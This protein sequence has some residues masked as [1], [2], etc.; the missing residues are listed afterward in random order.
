MQ[1]ISAGDVYFL[2]SPF[3][4]TVSPQHEKKLAYLLGTV[5]A[6]PA[7]VVRPPA[8]WDEYS[9]VDVIPSLTNG[10]PSITLSLND[11]FGYKTA[12]DYNFMPHTTHTVP[13]G[14]LGRYI[15][16]LTDAEYAEIMYAFHW[17][18]DRRM[19]ANPDMYAVPECYREVM[20]RE[21]PPVSAFHAKDCRFNID[22]NMV[23]HA[24]GSNTKDLDG[25]ALSV[26]FARSITPTVAAK[27]ERDP[28]YH[29]S[30]PVITQKSVQE[31]VAI[32]DAAPA[33]VTK[34]NGTGTTKPAEIN[35]PPSTFDQV[36]LSRVAK[37]YTLFEKYYP[38]P[39]QLEVRNPAVLTP[40]E[41]KEIRGDVG[42][43]RMKDLIAYYETFT[44]FDAW[45]L[46]PYLPTSTLSKMIGFTI[47]ETAALKRLCT[48]FKGM[49]ENAYRDRLDEM[50]KPDTSAPTQSGDS[51]NRQLTQPQIREILTKLSPY[52]T[53]DKIDKIPQ[54]LR[55]DFL[56]VP[57][58]AIKR[59]YTGK[60]FST[61]YA[62][63]V[64]VYKK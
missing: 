29:P 55:P 43:N 26:N 41:I 3:H 35:F 6:R 44:P 56:A 12:A 17:V 24:E 18:H 1:N 34:T 40:D 14:R 64:S 9:T 8:F 63:A 28:D 2:A 48:F 13:I 25:V 22:H 23:I 4:S 51:A 21:T 37:D 52:L 47:R 31:T 46:G 30:T 45:C 49:S 10:K 15:G 50:N 60:G 61:A 53:E 19:I 7:I 5:S 57:Q 58:Y 59:A 36:T 32:N 16:H 33:T 27:L 62:R 42:A 11:R 38:G 54:K 20:N 39:K